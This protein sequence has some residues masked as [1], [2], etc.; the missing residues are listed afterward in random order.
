S[1]YPIGYAPILGFVVLMVGAVWRH[2]LLEIT[3]ALA[4]EQII[5]GIA[6]ALLVLDREGTVRV[7]NQ[8]ASQLF[9]Y[10][11]AALIGKPVSATMGGLFEQDL[12]DAVAAGGLIRVHEIPYRTR[13]GETVI[14]DITGCVTRDRAGRPIAFVF[15]A[16]D[17]SAQRRLE[18]QLYQSRKLEALGHL[19]G[20]IARELET[21]FSV[22]SRQGMLFLSSLEHS[23]TA[24]GMRTSVGEMKMA[25]D[26]AAELIGQLFAFSSSRGSRPTLL[27]LNGLVANLRGVLRW[28]LGS[29]IQLQ[30][31]LDPALEWV[32]VDPAQTEQVIITLAASARDA[33][34]S[35]GRLPPRGAK[36]AGAS[37]PASSP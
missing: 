35:G 14:L 19:A 18:E 30:T 28:V 10:A 36:R 32:N 8:G 5:H 9:G 33:M 34:T 31:D 37:F 16:R 22:I 20:D 13:D 7:A 12:I 4:A 1:I 17:V 3:P 25:V 11:P 15:I 24:P 6:D 2:R 21:N 27:D 26:R 23:A 29:E